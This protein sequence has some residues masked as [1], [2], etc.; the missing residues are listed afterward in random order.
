M[1]QL[2]V[3]DEELKNAVTHWFKSLA[4]AFYVERIGKLVKR[5][6]KWLNNGRTMLKIAKSCIFDKHVNF[7][8]QCS[9]FYS[10]SEVTF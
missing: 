1:R 2:F 6:D 7:S 3:E 10:D 5:Y 8:S 9:V 4:A